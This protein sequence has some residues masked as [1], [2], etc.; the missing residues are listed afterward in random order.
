[1]CERTA[2]K[3]QLHLLRRLDGA[4][5]RTLWWESEVSHFHFYPDYTE[6]AGILIRLLNQGHHK[7]QSS[8]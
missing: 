1:M 2:N 6:G 8:L 5:L 3:R 4:I 7:V